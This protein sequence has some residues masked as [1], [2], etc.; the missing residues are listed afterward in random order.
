V[1]ATRF[2]LASMDPIQLRNDWPTQVRLSFA[3]AMI[4]ILITTC[5]PIVH[6]AG[7]MLLQSLKEHLICGDLTSEDI[8][9]YY[10][11]TYVYLQSVLFA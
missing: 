5:R 10:T 1:G 8:F 4:N 9:F 2:R 3:W 7:G 6:R 11:T